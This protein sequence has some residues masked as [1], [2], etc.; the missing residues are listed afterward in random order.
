MDRLSISYQRHESSGL[1]AATSADLPGLLVMG[2]SFAA[3][4]Q[5]LPIVAADLI[6]KQRGIDVVVFWDQG[7]KPVAGFTP[8][9]SEAKVK[10][11]V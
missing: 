3:L 7:Q 2:E 8:I 5:E 4:E 6:K 1:L 10:E 9:V 11:L